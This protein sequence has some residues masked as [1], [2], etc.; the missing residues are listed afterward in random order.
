MSHY[1][2]L[3][4]GSGPAGHRAAIQAAKRGKHVGLIERKP[5][6]GGAGLQTGTIPSKALREIA[7]SATMGASHG[8]RNVHPNIVRQHN[9]LSESIQQKDIVIDKQESVFLSQLMRNGVALTYATHQN[10][11][12]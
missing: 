11:A 7:Y 6:I 2:I 4:I 5:R 8:M 9:F 10:T 1:D 3:V 12:W